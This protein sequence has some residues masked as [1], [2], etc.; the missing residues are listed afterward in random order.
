MSK[1]T[2]SAYLKMERKY[3]Y[4]AGKHEWLP[5]V[6]SFRGEDYEFSVF[7]KEVEVEVDAP[8]D[9]GPTAAQVA[10]VQRER[11]EAVAEFTKKLA[12]I[13]ERLKKYQ[14]ITLEPAEVTE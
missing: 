8:D 12:E 4:R 10:A 11:A 7:V 14:A 5:S 3:N 6:D 1:Q 2:I 13:D 9:F